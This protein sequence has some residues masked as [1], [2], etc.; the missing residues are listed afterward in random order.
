MKIYGHDM[1]MKT[2]LDKTIANKPVQSSTDKSITNL[3]PS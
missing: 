1:H 3:L 2:R